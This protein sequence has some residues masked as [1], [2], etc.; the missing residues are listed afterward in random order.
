MS[1]K[2]ITGSIQARVGAVLVKCLV[3]AT[4]SVVDRVVA[5]EVSDAGQ[6]GGVQLAR[7]ARPAQLDREMKCIIMQAPWQ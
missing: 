1:E 4:V 2:Q 6:D 7:K 5:R 3:G